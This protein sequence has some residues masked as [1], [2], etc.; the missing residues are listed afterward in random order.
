MAG[1]WTCCWRSGGGGEGRSYLLREKVYAGKAPCFAGGR[2]GRAFGKVGYTQPQKPYYDLS[3]RFRWLGLQ[4]QTNGLRPVRPKAV[5]GVPVGATPLAKV[6][7]FDTNA[8]PFCI[9]GQFQK[10]GCNV[11]W[12]N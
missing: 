5:Q 4:A 7:Q 11:L 2:A 12:E 8:H 6:M 9:G 10:G 1:W 3:K